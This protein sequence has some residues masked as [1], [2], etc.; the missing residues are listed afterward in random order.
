MEAWLVSWRVLMRGRS[1]VVLVRWRVSMYHL[2]S[3]VDAIL[4]FDMRASMGLAGSELEI[5]RYA[6]Y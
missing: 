3:C 1:S 4:R 6:S 2:V 5:L